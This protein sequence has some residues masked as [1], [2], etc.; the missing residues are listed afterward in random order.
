LNSSTLSTT[1]ANREISAGIGVAYNTF[2]G[3][4]TG[5]ILTLNTTAPSGTQF[6]EINGFQLDL[7]SIQEIPEPSTYAMMFA[8]L[9]ILVWVRRRMGGKLSHL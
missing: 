2:T 8:G 4:V 5:D 9:G 3:T 6:T 7:A 1:G